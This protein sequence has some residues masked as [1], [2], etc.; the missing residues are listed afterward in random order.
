VSW[1]PVVRPVGPLPPGRYWGR[2]LLLLVL[3]AL[4]V[5]LIVHVASGGQGPADRPK[6]LPAAS[7]SATPSPT[8]E[9]SIAAP[10]T[11][12]P[13]GACPATQLE[14]TISAN[15][16]SYTLSQM[17]HFTVTVLNTGQASCVADLGSPG[18]SVLVS[19]NGTQVWGSSDCEPP[20]AEPVN[21]TPGGSRTSVTVWNEDASNPT[22]CPTPGGQVAAG[23]YSAVAEAGG[24]TSAAVQFTVR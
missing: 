13:G 20:Q 1:Q 6:A 15:A 3:L 22:T 24:A 14:I 5:W 7:P 9:A 23:T 2:R 17:P 10:P 12:A 8:P 11:L 19:D 4:I 21:L 18:R 16:A